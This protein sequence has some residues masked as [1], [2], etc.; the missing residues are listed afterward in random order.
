MDEILASQR[1]MLIREGKPADTVSDEKL[2]ELYGKHLRRVEDWLSRQ[3]NFS[4]LYIHYNDILSDPRPSVE[5]I[6]RFLGGRLYAEAMV[7]VVDKGLYR[8]RRSGAR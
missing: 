3:A 1:Q 6:Q 2:A 8:Q 4:V 7:G 5:K